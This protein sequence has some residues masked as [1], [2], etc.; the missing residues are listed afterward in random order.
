[1]SKLGSIEGRKRNEEKEKEMNSK[2]KYTEEAYL[3]REICLRDYILNCRGLLSNRLSFTDAMRLNVG[4]QRCLPPH[5]DK[6]GLIRSEL[7]VGIVRSWILDAFPQATTLA[8]DMN[9]LLDKCWKADL[10]VFVGNHLGVPIQVKSSRTTTKAYIDLIKSNG[11]CLTINDQTV[12]E[13]L[14]VMAVDSFNI[15]PTVVIHTGSSGE[16]RRKRKE[17][18]LREVASQLAIPRRRVA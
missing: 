8:P 13:I 7:S 4:G 15:R 2:C 1:M 9:S 17:K 5:G 14:D 3:G 16:N 12:L 6:E 18:F 11:G 10:L